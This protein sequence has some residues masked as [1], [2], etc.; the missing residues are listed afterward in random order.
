[1]ASFSRLLSHPAIVGLLQTGAG[2]TTQMQKDR[3]EEERLR[4]EL[5]MTTF[6]RQM[7]NLDADKARSQQLADRAEANARED[8]Q[9]AESRYYS[10]ISAGR[11][12]VA[13]DIATGMG[14]QKAIDLTQQASD[15][16]IDAERKKVLAAKEDAIKEAVKRVDGREDDPGAWGA[17]EIYLNAM[18]KLHPEW[19][20]VFKEDLSSFRAQKDSAAKAQKD[21]LEGKNPQ[22]NETEEAAA[23]TVLANPQATQAELAYVAGMKGIRPATALLA[24]QKANGTAPISNDARNEQEIL[25]KRRALVEDR[26]KT[27]TE[28]NVSLTGI[29]GQEAQPLT[30]ELVAQWNRDAEMLYPSTRA[31]DGGGQGGTDPRKEAAIQSVMSRLG[32]SREEAERQLLAEMENTPPPSG[33]SSALASGS[34]SGAAAPPQVPGVSAASAQSE[35]VESLGG[36]T[37]LH[38]AVSVAPQSLAGDGAGVPDRFRTEVQINRQLGVIEAEMTRRIRGGENVDAVVQSMISS[39]PQ[40]PRDRIVGIGDNIRGRVN[41]MVIAPESVVR[42]RE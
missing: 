8:A 14:G 28:T 36:G 32:I 7:A 2:I 33:G 23:R 9:L 3:E 16:F 41:R 27:W 31:G 12:D 29:G 20:D 22:Y 21:K 42:L 5:A 25:K 1:M 10:A 40:I 6:E 19:G 11:P 39:Y 15:M 30:Q 35:P 17:A 4:R 18:K 13:G 38:R 24:I 26:Y 37:G 34:D